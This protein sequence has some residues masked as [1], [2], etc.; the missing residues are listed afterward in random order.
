MAQTACNW[1]WNRLRCMRAAICTPAS[2][3]PSAGSA[4]ASPATGGRARRA[5]A[6]RRC[7]RPAAVERASNKYVS[8]TFR[9]ESQN[10][11]RR[12]KCYVYATYMHPSFRV[13]NMADST[14]RRDWPCAGAATLHGVSRQ[15]AG[16]DSA[17]RGGGRSTCGCW[18]ERLCGGGR[19]KLRAAPAPRV[20]L[21]TR[22]GCARHALGWADWRGR[23][24]DVRLRRCAPH[25][26]RQR[27]AGPCDL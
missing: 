18:R 5:T 22:A 21:R 1:V 2:M 3:R 23:S 6:A 12:S 26:A 10:R 11:R 16:A 14:T 4:L 25:Q 15:L 20:A 13:Q 8:N 27:C 9:I 24:P 17:G 7:A 19:L